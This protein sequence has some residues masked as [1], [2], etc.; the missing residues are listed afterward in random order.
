MRERESKTKGGG[1]NG[2]KTKGA[3]ERLY[4]TVCQ[5]GK[6]SEHL[7]N[8]EGDRL[9]RRNDKKEKAHFHLTHV[10]QY[11]NVVY[12][13]N[14]RLHGLYVCLRE[15]AKCVLCSYVN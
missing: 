2:L 5:S 15:R 6:S 4:L 9:G 13:T 10:L 7:L 12:N 11:P 8:R 1:R 3:E 14:H